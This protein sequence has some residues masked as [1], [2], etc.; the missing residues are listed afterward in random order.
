M[1]IPLEAVI[2]E[3]HIIGGA[4]QSATR[5][6]AVLVAP[7]RAAR[8]RPG[9]TLFVLVELRGPEPLP[10]E[11]LVD[12]IGEAY[13]K[14][15]GTITSALR[16]AL[17]A[18]NDWLWERNVSAPV[19]DRFRAGI[20]CA[21]LRGAEVLIAQ[22]GPAAA[23]VAHYGQVERFPA[24]DI[25]PPALGVSR[26]V[27]VRF[28]RAALSPGD[29]LL[30]CDAGA[31]ER[32]SEE[33]VAKV[34][35]YTG[36]EAALQNLEKLTG[37]GDLIALVIESAAEAKTKAALEVSVKKAAPVE[38]ARPAPA[39][40]TLPQPEPEPAASPEPAKPIEPVE[41][42]VPVEPAEPIE[43]IE[44]AEQVAP[45]PIEP[46]KPPAPLEPVGP[47]GAIKPVEQVS[48]EPEPIK[49]TRSIQPVALPK[50]P[51][52]PEPTE[53]IEE[54]PIEEELFE[55]IPWTQRVGESV[56]Q[57]HLGERVKAIGGSL[58][59]GLT[60]AARGIATILQRTLPEGTLTPQPRGKGT[61]MVLGGFAVFIP[62]MVAVLVTSTYMQYSTMARF[63]ALLA[64]AQNDAAQAATLVDQ[65]A[66]RARW[67]SAYTQAVT[68]LQVRPGAPEARQ[69][70]D[71]AQRALD[72]IDNVVRLK[73]SLLWDFKTPGPR[74]LAAQG[75]NLFVLDRT[76]NRVFQLTL[77]EAGDGVTDRGEP[78]TRAYK[79]QNVS[80]R[81]VGDLIDLVWMPAGGART[82]SSLLVLDSGGLLEYDLAWNVS[83][84]PLGQG[85]VPLGARAVS[86]F[87]GNLYVL[88][89]ATSHL[90]RYRPQ[91]SGYAAAES[92]FD[93]SPGGLTTAIDVAIDGSVYVLLADGHIRKFFGGQE[94][95]FAASGI[96][97]P[98]K[99]PVALSA[100]AEA[101]QGAVYVADAGGARIVQLNTDGAFVR[102]LRAI[103]DAFDAL[104]DVLVDERG[105]RLF[106]MSGGK[107]YGARLPAGP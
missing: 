78:P 59:A 8:G 74:R 9:D 10:Y 14:T 15:P 53:E 36:V 95:P 105:G 20:S 99:R 85:P 43:E 31:A 58:A 2:G 46:V 100:D 90:W 7:R 60:I 42:I 32:L 19:A 69:I 72:Q 44:F 22:A 34:L 38:P 24:R 13:W 62:V 92:Y 64:G 71:D 73:T 67:A 30:L 51:P 40:S 65:T 55:R 23:Y 26:G 39:P 70:R 21:V 82:R 77:N 45:E 48:V 102:Q 107:L 52:R 29:A 106:V 96:A 18:A 94:R 103:G 47:I 68:A 27:E 3:L 41:R 37:S 33:A 66:R 50:P 104:E 57:L 17:T 25:V 87:S 56:A 93:P 6:T 89:P 86:A 12:R 84:V 80:D 49:P 63:Q 91:S 16:A 97:D 28:S 88:D 101:R 5:P 79:T 11:T 54:A 75:V 35:V 98:I 76:A 4:R 1:S 61:T 81:Q 83:S